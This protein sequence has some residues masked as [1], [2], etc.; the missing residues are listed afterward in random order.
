LILFSEIARQDKR[1]HT[2]QDMRL[3]PG[4]SPTKLDAYFHIFQHF[5]KIMHTLRRSKMFK[6][7]NSIEKITLTDTHLRLFL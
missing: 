7:G 3:T 6:I 2:V 5:F 1:S 4:V